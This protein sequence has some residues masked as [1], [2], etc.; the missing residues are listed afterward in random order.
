[1][2]IIFLTLLLSLTSSVE[3]SSKF[4]RSALIMLFD[5]SKDNFK[6]KGCNK[7][8][9]QPTDLFQILKYRTTFNKNCDLEGEVNLR[10]LTPFPVN[11]K[12]KNL[13]SYKN[14]EATA[15][16]SLGLE[17]PPRIL[18]E[19]SRAQLNGKDTIYFNAFYSGE[20]IPGKK[21]E[22]KPGSEVIKIVVYDK[23]FS[24]KIDEFTV[25]MK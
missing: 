23:N 12:V 1:M 14:L 2:Y 24:K 13:D 22:V 7:F 16:I 20:V 25:K 17:Q 6:I 4:N 19:L 3:A 18:G 8:S 10:L 21:I 11:M 9:L 15:K 5:Q